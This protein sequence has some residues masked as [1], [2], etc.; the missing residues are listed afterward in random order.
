MKMG[1]GVE[2]AIHCATLLATL[3][4]GAALP[5]KSLAEYHGVSESYLLK[6]LKALAAGG[7]LE[8][9][10][11]PKGGYRLARE[12]DALTFLDIV[13]AV[14]GA[15]P[16]FRCTEIRQRGPVR[17]DPT[18]CRR[19]CAIYAIMQEAEEAWRETLKRRTVGDIL[20]HLTETLPPRSH[21]DTA[22]WIRE[23]ARMLP[24][25]GPGSE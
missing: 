7:I 12:P 1:E 4:A 13:E 20:R 21:A 18:A 2:W 15:A 14:E 24:V 11:G 10:P 19:P 25:I 8:S 22:A 6:H 17:A 23:N 3:P 16:A 5:A 9:V